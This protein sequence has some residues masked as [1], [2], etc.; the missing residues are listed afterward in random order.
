M[1]VIGTVIF[2]VAVAL[3]VLTTVWQRRQAARDHAP[4]DVFLS[5]HKNVRRGE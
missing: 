3:V 2:A 5:L 4:A 1:N